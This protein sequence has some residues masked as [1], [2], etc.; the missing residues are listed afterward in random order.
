MRG[1]LVKWLAKLKT[2]LHSKHIVKECFH[3][4]FTYG[5]NETTTGNSKFNSSLDVSLILRSLVIENCFGLIE[6]SGLHREATSMS[7]SIK[8]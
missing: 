3:L 5:V 4:V 2:R 1:C 6:F 8:A 7:I